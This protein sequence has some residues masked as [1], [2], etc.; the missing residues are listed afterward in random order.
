MK[1]KL[2]VP[3]VVQTSA[4][5]CGPASLK[6]LLEGFGVSVSYG[7][8]RE[9][10]QT[11]VDGTSIDTLEEIAKQLGL[12]A[13]Q[14][15]LPLDH[16]LAPEAE[17][18][19][20][21]VVSRLPNGFTHFVVVWRRHGSLVQVMD[22]GSGRRWMS[23]E[24]LLSDLYVHTMA[25]PAGS[26]REWA[27]SDEFVSVLAK[28]LQKLGISKRNKLIAS[29]K[30]DPGWQPLATLDAATRLT[31]AL[32]RSGGI[33]PGR[34]AAVV[35][36]RTIQDPAGIPKSYWCARP[37]PDDA[38]GQP[39]V[40][41]RGAV[42]VRARGLQPPKPPP[43]DTPTDEKKPLP[44]E[45][46]AALEE[47]PSRPGRELLRLLRA[48]G[49]LTPLA[50]LVALSLA[51]FGGVGE[52]LLF[53]GL[54]DVGRNLGLWHQRFAAIG[55]LVVLLAGLLLLELP[56]LDAVAGL[57]RR[58]ESRLRVAFLTKI[59]RLGDRY[60]S[61]RPTSDMAERSHA[62]Q[63]V[64]TLPQL[65]QSL[66][67]SMMELLVTVAG[68]VWLDPHNATVAIAAGV[69]GVMLPLLVQPPLTERDL[70]VRIHD[71]SLGRFYLDALLGLIAV[72]THGAERALR[73]EHESLLVEWAHASRAL[74]RTAVVIEGIQALVGFGLAVWL[75]ASYL[76]RGA[77][78]GG[79]LLLV[80]W[81]LN[82]PNLGQE[83]AVGARQ[84][85]SIRNLTLR[86][87][88]PLGAKEEADATLAPP[89][90]AAT[91]EGV[92]LRFEEVRVLA[93]GHVILEGVN[94]DVPP[95]SHV[96]VVG[97]SGAGK[98]SLVGLLLGWHRV[99]SG[100]I[101]ADGVE[102]DGARVAQLRNET[103]WVD[104]AVQLWNR[105]F[106]DNLHYGAPGQP[107]PLTQILDSA[108]LRR[109]LEQLPDGLQTSLGEGGA[110]VSGG[111]GQRVRFGR[112]LQRKNARLV[113]LDEPFR[114]LD[115]DK[116]RDLLARA[117]QW[118]PKATLLCITHDVGETLGFPR[119][120]VIEKGRL[121][122]DDSP[123]E[124]AA[125]ASRY[126][127]LLA[128]EMEVRTGLWSS[129]EWRRVRLS[130]GRV[131]GDQ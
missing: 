117:R 128:A 34:E 80:Y 20:A 70:R 73:R 102:L 105:S 22:P 115:R 62:V 32:V 51:A 123:S 53:R 46:V 49:V 55:A 29:A 92:H 130:G 97:P 7:R 106:V 69:L 89:P 82:L 112:A 48:D 40:Y 83:I 125:R 72:R 33:R 100:R 56:I 66:L 31:D 88:E 75:L 113:I 30:A 120:L 37:A 39:Q 54:F 118:W 25:V 124:L 71:G 9:A 87:L 91:P 64:R 15:M 99:Q 114:G 79:A 96:A 122:E 121:I 42:M 58:L 68:L 19:P 81:A 17:A 28:R 5:D 60:F 116:R 18:L 8:L 43:E 119:V 74:L 77:D 24:K 86:L 57:G 3:E 76:G 108:D 90:P 12:D 6:A 47:P 101:S 26:W 111:E 78:V 67:L 131:E 44:P 94:V 45:L 109:L 103:A 127:A 107:A 98:S 61:S 63:F 110:L 84:Y 85:P 93:G 38:E 4:M 27:A 41:L 104:P 23:C 52:A 65:G 126:R 2:I 35:L 13:E 95:G 14:V 21:L 11:D 10:C 59:P 1:T 129:A 16:V 50:L 36:E